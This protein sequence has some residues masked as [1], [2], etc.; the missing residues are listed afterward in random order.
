MAAKKNEPMTARR[1]ANMSA[2]AK[3]KWLADSRYAHALLDF[4]I[5][6]G[7]EAHSNALIDSCALCLGVSWGRVLAPGAAE[8]RDVDAEYAADHLPNS[9]RAL[10]VHLAIN[11]RANVS[12]VTGSGR[13][14][15]DLRAMRLVTLIAPNTYELTPKGMVAAQLIA[16]E[17]ARRS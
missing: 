3:A 17:V 7:G 1:F 15:L 9:A 8:P 10:L 12:S 4:T 13:T 2:K 11:P 16:A 14:M 6:C 5:P